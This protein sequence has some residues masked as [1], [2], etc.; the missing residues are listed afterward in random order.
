MT[1]SEWQTRKRRIDTKLKSLT[2]AWDIRPYR[3]GMDTSTLDGVAVEEFPTENGP[4]DYALFVQGKLLGIIEAKKVSV[5]PE[6]VLEQAKRYAR[7]VEQ[8]AGNWNGYK[9][10]FLY[11]TNGEVIHYIDVRTQPAYSRRLASFHTASAIAEKFE[12]PDQRDWFISHPIQIK[13]LRPYQENAIRNAEQAIADGKRSMLVAMA[14]GCGKTY[15]TVSQ[16]YRLLESGVA[17]RILFLVD[18]R[19]LAV[20][21]VNAFSAFETNKGNKFT[22]EYE[23]YSQRFRKEDFEDTEPFKPEVLPNDYLTDPQAKHTYVYVSTVQRMAINLGFTEALH[24]QNSGDAEVEEG[25]DTLTIPIHAFDVIIA[26]ECHRGYT[27]E[28]TAAWR[29][30]F[31]YFDAIKVGLTATPAQHTVGLFKE[32]VSRYGVREAIKDGWLVDYDAVK[33][34]SGVRMD[35]VFLDEGEHVEIVDTDTGQAALDALEDERQFDASKI[36]RE[37]TAP[38]SNR[39]IIQEIAQYAYEHEKQTGRFPKILIFAANDLRHTSHAQQLVKI[40]REEFGQ[41]DAFVQ[42]ITGAPNVDRPLQKIREFRNRPTPKVVV[43]VDMLTTGVDIPALEFIVF[44]RPVK[45][46]IL[47]EQM[48]GRGT[49]RCEEINKTHFM[50]FDCF[51]GS[52]MDYFKGTSEFNLEFEEMQ[53]QYSTLGIVDVIE[54]IYQNVDRQY[55]TRILVKRLQRINR[56]MSGE[57]R[58]QFAAFIPNG[59]MQTFAAGLPLQLEKDFTGAMEILRNSKFQDLLLNYPKAKRT[60]LRAVEVEDTVESEY[61]FRRGDEHLK[62]EDYLE[63]FARFVQEQK[64][65]IAAFQILIEKPKEWRAPVLKDLRSDLLKNDYPVEDLQRAHK[66][67]SHK[68]LADVIS[69]VKH[70]AREEEPVFTAEE[71]VDRAMER[72]AKGKTFSMEQR[73]WLGLIREH[74]VENLSLDIEDFKI[75]PIFERKGGYAKARKI[76]GDQLDDLVEEINYQ[77]AA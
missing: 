52:L 37:I 57:A 21:A 75:L 31:D 39:K 33:I 1:E 2:P 53:K 67:V 47:W 25:A 60:F 56:D 6:N 9:A 77:L 3:E 63:A 69:I 5:S 4:A 44:L 66:R 23:V 15:T 34:K 36:E 12:R 27:A 17:K 42:K 16:I 61:I 41:G 22:Q 72:V 49:R 65:E 29:R 8:G 7:G 20:Q 71:R 40:C 18:R 62:P 13:G 68:D 24:P 70:A 74:L 59:D 14:T 64:D 46:R 28:Q 30:V 10:P 43:S 35:G 58:E 55:H 26:D 11:A 50:V 48:L 45:S 76:F 54:N 38:D 32:V 19:A 73:E 51:D